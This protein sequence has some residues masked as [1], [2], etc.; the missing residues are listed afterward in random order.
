MRKYKGLGAVLAVLA[1]TLAGCESADK[2]AGLENDSRV[3]LSAK[4]SSA[5]FG[6]YVIQVNAMSTADLTPEIAQGYG[7]VRSPNQALVNLVV[8][9][10]E[11]G[12]Q[13]PVGGN[14]TV[15][16]ANLTGQLKN[17]E[18]REI[19][20]LTDGGSIYY[21]GLVSVDDRETINFDFDVQPQGSNRLLLIRYTH[22]F[23]TK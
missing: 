15:S 20:E 3:R 16:A 9:R 10:E 14:V 7:I 5:P 21:I 2:S 17:L 18:L 12:S 23:Y 6:A 22:E 4:Q 8:L 13:K 19:N 11:N 1:A